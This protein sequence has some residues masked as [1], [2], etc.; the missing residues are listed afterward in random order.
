MKELFSIFSILLISLNNSFNSSFIDEIKMGNRQS[1]KSAIA[2]VNVQLDDIRK[3]IK[4]K[5]SVRVVALLDAFGD[6]NPE[7]AKEGCQYLSYMMNREG[8][9]KK[10][11]TMEMFKQRGFAETLTKII[12]ANKTHEAAGWACSVV[13]HVT[14]PAATNQSYEVI[15][16]E[17]I[18]QGICEAIYQALQSSKDDFL[19]EQAN[20]AKTAL[21]RLSRGLE[22]FEKLDRENIN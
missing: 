20:E 7:L 2:R 1:D 4:D 14:K 9:A 8:D 17:L 5:N 13:T 3:L 11:S 18:T 19:I 12:K 16:D 10:E 22:E 15:A 6:K 21:T